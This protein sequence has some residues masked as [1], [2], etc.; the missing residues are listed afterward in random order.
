MKHTS[1]QG[2][3]PH[4]SYV[5]DLWVCKL[6]FPASRQPGIQYLVP[7]SWALMWFLFR[8]GMKNSRKSRTQNKGYVSTF[9]RTFI[10][11]ISLIATATTYHAGLGWRRRGLIGCRLLLRLLLRL[12]IGR[13]LSGRRD[14]LLLI[15]RDLLLWH[16]RLRCRRYRRYAGLIQLHPGDRWDVWL[17]GERGTRIDHPWV[18]GR[19]ETKFCLLILFNFSWSCSPVRTLFSLRFYCKIHKHSHTSSHETLQTKN[20]GQHKV[21]TGNSQRL[22]WTLAASRAICAAAWAAVMEAGFCGQAD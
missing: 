8:K 2:L 13:L 4:M 16:H 19:T 5:M 1:C 17:I 10:G 20:P 9:R 11:F 21:F 12:L 14:L 15:G 22:F 3:S 18:W 7:V 6:A